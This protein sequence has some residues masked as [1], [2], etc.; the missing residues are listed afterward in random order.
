MRKIIIFS[1][2]LSIFVI[3][4]SYFVGNTSYPMAGEKKAL[5]K[6]NKCQ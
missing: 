1:V 6:L 2:F 5:V 3:M 4:L